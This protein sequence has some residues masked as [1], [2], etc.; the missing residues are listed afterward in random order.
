MKISITIKEKLYKSLK[1]YCNLNG[2]DIETFCNDAINKELMLKKY[3]D[4]PFGV[5]G[6]EEKSDLPEI[7]IDESKIQPIPT[8]TEIIT[9][10]KPFKEPDGYS[11]LMSM[12]EITSVEDVEK[13]ENNKEK[14]KNKRRRL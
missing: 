6:K 5:I 7:K 3:G 10:D 9:N 11:I 12:E 2:I 13:K 14:T 4:I 8:A 1:D